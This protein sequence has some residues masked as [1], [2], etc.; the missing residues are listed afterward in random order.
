[1]INSCTSFINKKEQIKPNII[2]ISSSEI[3]NNGMSGIYMIKTPV[4]I[5]D[6]I[7]LDNKEFAIHIPEEQDKKQLAIVQDGQVDC[8]GTSTNVHGLIGGS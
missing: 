5:Y 4:I 3:H 2:K 6:V 8:N 7:I 1:M